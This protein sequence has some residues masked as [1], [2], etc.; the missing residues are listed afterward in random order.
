MIR[1]RDTRTI[2][3]ILWMSVFVVSGALSDYTPAAQRYVA[4]APALALVLGFAIA[5]LVRFLGRFGAK[6]LKIFSYLGLVIILILS[7]DELLFYFYTFTPF[8]TLGG[9]TGKA[10]M[11][12]GE[13]LQTKDNNWEVLFFGSPEMNYRSIASISYLAPQ[14]EGTDIVLPWGAEANPIPNR[15]NVIF[16]FLPNHQTDLEKVQSNY[17]GG[18]LLEERTW[19][20]ELLYWLYEV[21]AIN[22]GQSGASP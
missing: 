11:H 12:L 14:V 17:P 7:V 9:S 16:V 8:S 2:L 15:K 1:L 5:E 10:A 6:S 21:E 22:N 3:L 19:S 18:K 13:Y 20:H 4:V